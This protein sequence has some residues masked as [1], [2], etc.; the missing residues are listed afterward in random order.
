L[1]A[2]LL[3]LTLLVIGYGVVLFI[4]PLIALVAAVVVTLASRHTRTHELG[5]VILLLGFLVIAFLVSFAMY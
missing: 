2:E 5:L 1:G 3:F 4:L